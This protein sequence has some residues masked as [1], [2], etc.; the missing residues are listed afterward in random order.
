MPDVT[1]EDPWCPTATYGSRGEKLEAL[2][3]SP[4]GL[5][6]TPAANPR[7]EG[8]GVVGWGLYRS[9]LSSHTDGQVP[10][11]SKAF[12]QRSEFLHNLI[13]L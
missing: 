9:H 10:R 1:T 12:R 4:Q 3:L 13:S 8:V 11:G 6:P 2:G 7:G 5:C